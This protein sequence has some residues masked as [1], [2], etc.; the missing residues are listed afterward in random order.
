Q[1][2]AVAD[3]DHA[4]HL[5]EI[6]T[7]REIGKMMHR[8]E[9]ARIVFSPDSRHLLTTR[10]SSIIEIWDV[11]N[12]SF[13]GALPRFQSEL[14]FSSNGPFV[15]TLVD[16]VSVQVWDLATA[17][18]VSTITHEASVSRIALTPDGRLLVTGS[19]D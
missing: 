14:A 8:S 17:R 3:V 19:S 4:A 16:A 2:L 7:G 5:W 11:I 10:D 12:G 6:A 1:Y 13:V 9:D 18:P 15:S